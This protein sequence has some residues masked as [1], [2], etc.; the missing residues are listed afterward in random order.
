MSPFIHFDDIPASW[1]IAEGGSSDKAGNPKF[2]YL[3]LL[4]R[5]F[6]QRVTG[7]FFARLAPDLD[8]KHCSIDLSDECMYYTMMRF[9]WDAENIGHIAR[10]GVAPREAEEVVTA[11]D[12][13]IVPARDRRFS[14]YGATATGRSVRV[15]YEPIDQGDLRVITAYPIRQHVL[16]RIH[17]EI[18]P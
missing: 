1:R 15:I 17:R 18:Q 10:H 11:D 7:R 6:V 3:F 14:A 8:R 5:Q 2:A 4:S 9:I 12:T 13:L 16:E